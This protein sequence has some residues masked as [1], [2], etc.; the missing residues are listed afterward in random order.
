MTI[1]RASNPA[2]A[3]QRVQCTR[4]RGWTPVRG[5]GFPRGALLLEAILAVSIFVMAGL[6]ISGAVSGSVDSLARSRDDLRAADLARSVMAKLEAGAAN[7][8]DLSGPVPLWED[9]EAA[10]EGDS[11][12]FE[13]GFA[14]APARPSLWEVEIETEPSEFAGLTR[15]SV[16]AFRW[17]AEG[18]GSDVAVEYRLHQLVRLSETGEDRAGAEDALSE[19]ARRGEERARRFGP[20]EPR[21]RPGR[22]GEGD[23]NRPPPPSGSGGRP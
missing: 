18:P 19:A 2:P 20:D 7:L 14:D 22:A 1:G 5:S 11:T 15:V 9:D 4:G 16:R 23:G 21:P 3:A 12:E 13:G 6:A 10:R 17:G 8:R